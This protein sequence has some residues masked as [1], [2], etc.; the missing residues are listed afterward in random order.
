MSIYPVHIKFT[1]VVSRMQRIIHYVKRVVTLSSNSPLCI[2]YFK[3]MAKT[4]R[5]SSLN[6]CMLLFT[7]AT[8]TVLIFLGRKGSFGETSDSLKYQRK[9]LIGFRLRGC[10]YVDLSGTIEFFKIEKRRNQD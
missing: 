2:L 10:R 7:V 9:L 5:V 1:D 4:M 3:G 8:A 6:R